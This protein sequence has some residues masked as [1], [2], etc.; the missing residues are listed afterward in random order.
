MNEIAQHF[1]ETYARGGEVDGGWKFGKALQQSRLDYSPDSLARLDQLLAAIRERA[2]PVAADFLGDVQGRNFCS[3][4][5]FYLMAVVNRRTHAVIEWH[6]HASAQAAVPAGTRLPQGPFSRLVAIAP[7]QGAL[8]T[9][10]G[11]V[12]DALF[13]EGVR[14]PAADWIAA[15]IGQIERE[16]PAAWA[17]AARDMG[18]L[19]A[20]LMFMVADGGTAIHTL[21]SNH[22]GGRKILHMIMADEPLKAGRA[23]LD[24]NRDGLPW[25]TF[26]YAGY[27]PFGDGSKAHA[28]VVELRTYG[29]QPLRLSVA[30]MYRPASPGSPFAILEPQGLSSSA[31][32]AQSA[33]LMPA[34][35]AGI[36]SFKW[37]RG[38]WDALRE[39]SAKVDA[40]SP[41]FAPT[42]QAPLDG[43]RGDDPR[44]TYADGEPIRVGDAVLSGDCV[45]PA[46]VV[47]LPPDEYGRPRCVFEATDGLRRVLS[48]E[49]AREELQ[50][51]ARNPPDH[52][53]ACVA[54]LEDNLRQGSLHA[55]YVLGLLNWHGVGMPKNAGVGLRLVQAAADA[56]HAAA[57][58][59]IARI[60]LAG[61][62]VAADTAKG[63][64]YLQRSASRGH[65]R[66]MGLLGEM[67][68]TG[69]LVAV[70]FP[71]ALTLYKRAI[72]AGDAE[73]MLSMARLLLEG[74]RVPLDAKQAGALI[75]QAAATGLVA[76]IY[77]LAQRCD[78]GDG[79]PQDHARAVA[80]YE[81]AAAQGH[82]RSINNLADKYE[83]GLGVP[84]D[85]D[86]AVAL[87][88]QA[89]DKNIIAAWYSL[90]KMAAEGRGLPRD[91]AEAA[92]WMKLAAAHDFLQSRALLADYL[93]AQGPGR[94]ADAE[95]VLAQA[96]TLEPQA[97][98]DAAAKVSTGAADG[99]AR[100][101]AF[102][103]LMQAAR[104][105][106]AG[107]QF[108]VGEAYRRGVGV[109]A[110][111]Q[112]AME[113]LERAAGQDHAGAIRTLGE[114]YES[115]ELGERNS[116]LAFGY[117]LR[118]ARS[119]TG[120][121]AANA[122]Y[123]V[124]RMYEDGRGAT[125]DLSEALR[126]M[127]AAAD[128]GVAD[129]EARVALL[130]RAVAAAQGSGASEAGKKPGWK[131]W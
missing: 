8:Y 64:D 18:F 131:F 63:I 10:L 78:D 69:Q 87:Y 96:A 65:P 91:L 61:D 99:A 92:R 62:T 76:A 72:A 32:P 17:S 46:R 124:A 130:Q 98:V 26:G 25:L 122:A 109:D 12:H 120:A 36:Q 21:L 113:W 33:A 105:G 101:L 51:V 97:L 6:D 79:V 128:H 11:W 68:E 40:S 1:L 60:Y 123:R 70:D 13:G 27:F 86:K 111:M 90:G 104:R 57:E 54:Y 2:K 59:E 53:A 67:H 80:L 82:A 41:G 114:V 38:S 50:F 115:G 74:Q 73:A 81:Q 44:L 47:L 121:P 43:D 110:S 93:R 31:T 22:P 127:E 106:H 30:F 112:L 55:R 116:E 7:D 119:G 4:L 58:T 71:K 77:L 5:A 42:A 9:P 100:V 3:L 94:I 37:P 23:D 89:A 19:A 117:S 28:I 49:G 103:L 66:A 20:H 52:V 107:A 16:V 125:V 108:Q 24:A 95:R 83:N 29:E 129:A 88:R 84:Q 56:G 85:L 39:A 126:W 35:N 118:T 48:A 34:M 75:E 14:R 45:W 102:K 15:V